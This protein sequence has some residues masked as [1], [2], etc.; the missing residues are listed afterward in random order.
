[1]DSA[2]PDLTGQ[3]APSA[4]GPVLGLLTGTVHTIGWL[5]TYWW[6]LALAAV[7]VCT[8]RPEACRP[9]D[10]VRASTGV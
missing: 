7:V 10:R 4:S 1:M 5:V 2:A 8:R 6:V 3:A 9:G